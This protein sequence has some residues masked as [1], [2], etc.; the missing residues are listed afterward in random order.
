MRRVPPVIMDT[1]DAPYRPPWQVFIPLI[2]GFLAATCPAIMASSRDRRAVLS[3]L[4]TILI[5]P[6][7]VLFGASAAVCS[8]GWHFLLRGAAR[9]CFWH[10]LGGIAV[11]V[12]TAR[13][14][15]RFL[16]HKDGNAFRNGAAAVPYVHPGRASVLPYAGQRRAICKEDGR[17]HIVW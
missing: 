3:R 7:Y 8:D 9:S 16:F 5:N 4:I 13:L 12:I 11:G 14:L 10:V 15:R 1:A 6:F 17:H 2:M